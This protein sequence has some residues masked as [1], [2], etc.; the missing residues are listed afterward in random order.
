LLDFTDEDIHPDTSHHLLDTY[1]VESLSN[2]P[3]C[4]MYDGFPLLAHGG[5]IDGAI[6]YVDRGRQFVPVGHANSIHHY[7]RLGLYLFHTHSTLR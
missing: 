5:P 3:N 1:A 2:N 6:V 7:E 4:S